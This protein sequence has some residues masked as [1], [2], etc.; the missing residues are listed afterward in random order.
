MHKR[1]DKAGV[2]TYTLGMN[3]ELPLATALELVPR[4]L[5]LLLQESKDNMSTFSWISSLNIPEIKSVP[6]KSFEATEFLLKNGIKQ[7]TPHFR[8]IDR[9]FSELMDL[10]GK[11]VDLGLERV[12]LIG[13][14]APNDPEFQPSGLTTVAAI[15]EVRRQYPNLKIYAGIDQY[16]QSFREELD[17][18]FRKR[19]AGCDGFYTQPFF[20]VGMLELWLEQLADSELWAGIAPVISE[21]SRL[22]WVRTNKTV[23][24]PNY[25]FTMEYNTFIARKLLNAISRADQRAYLMPVRMDAKEFIARL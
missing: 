3:F 18:A 11:L 2:N 17:Y 25:Q 21:K 6:L 14:D 4:S 22:Y 9:T 19:D 7:V 12:L 16:R 13:G 8:M 10:V 24:P 1:I 15:R 23:F 5:D 20:S